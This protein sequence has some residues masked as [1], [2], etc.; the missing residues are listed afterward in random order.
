MESPVLWG[1]L[2]DVGRGWGDTYVL[3]EGRYEK[4]LNN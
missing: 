1:M 4:T 3:F 2:W